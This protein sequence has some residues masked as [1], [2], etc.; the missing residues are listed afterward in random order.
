MEW[1][2]IEKMAKVEGRM[3][4]KQFVEILEKN[5]LP[6]IEES[7]IFEKKVICQQAKNSKH[8]SKLA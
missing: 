6:N 7:S 1:N 2:G 4:A 5:L 8:N 3:D